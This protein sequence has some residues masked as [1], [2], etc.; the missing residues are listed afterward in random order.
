MRAVRESGGAQTCGGVVM[1]RNNYPTPPHPQE[2]RKRKGDRRRK[3]ISFAS[4]REMEGWRR[5]TSCVS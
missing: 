5:R 1:T 3:I 2:R 4:L